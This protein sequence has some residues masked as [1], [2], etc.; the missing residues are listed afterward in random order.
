MMVLKI[1]KLRYGDKAIIKIKNEKIGKG[2]EGGC[3]PAAVGDIGFFENPA[4]RAG[5]GYRRHDQTVV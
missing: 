1:L 3:Q 2:F 5:G 4:E